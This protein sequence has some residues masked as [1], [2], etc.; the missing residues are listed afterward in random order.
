MMVQGDL[1]ADVALPNID[2][3]QIAVRLAVAM[4]LNPDYKFEREL[5]CDGPLV[6]NEYI[7]GL[8]C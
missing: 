1:N 5:I 7:E 4:T 8:T 3:G 2:E 6:T